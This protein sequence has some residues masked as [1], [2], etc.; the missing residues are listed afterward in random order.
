MIRFLMLIIGLGLFLAVQPAQAVERKFSIF[1][2]ENIQIKGAIN[3]IVT[4]GKGVSAKAQANNRKTL[5]RVY[6][7]RNSKTLVIM[8][9]PKA[10]MNQSFDTDEKITVWVSTYAVKSIS[11]IGG[12]NV[13]LDKLSGRKSRVR[14]SGFGT[15]N[16]AK[17]D[18]DALDLAMNGGGLI[19]IG[20]QVKNGRIELLGSSILD[21]ASLTVE[22]LTL[23]HRGP[24]S[25]HI[26]ATREAKISDSGSG[27]ITIDGKPNCLVK[28]T[29]FSEIIC[30]PKG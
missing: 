29:G 11:V 25:S 16:I 22:K 8:V 19:N 1:S 26:S 21:G 7:D 24:A 14:L 5:D 23:F 9:R 15:L 13:S 12:G 4:T 6:L 3:V 30:N 2:F 18:S 27:K 10:N 17:V 20:G 28:T